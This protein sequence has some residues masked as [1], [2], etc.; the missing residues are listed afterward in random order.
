MVLIII[1]IISLGWL[2]MNQAIGYIYKAQLLSDPCELCRSNNPQL[3]RC[4]Y[5]MQKSNPLGIIIN[6]TEEQLNYLK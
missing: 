2:G 5:N 3:D 6:L 1:T 4:F